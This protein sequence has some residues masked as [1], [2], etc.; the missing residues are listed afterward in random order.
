MYSGLTAECGE[1]KTGKNVAS[2]KVTN[3]TNSKVP[4]ITFPTGIDATVIETKV[5]TVGKGPKITGSQFV[6]F[7]F[8]QASGATGEMTG[9]TKFDGTDIQSQYLQADGELCKA[10]GGV[11]EGSRVA[12]LIPSAIMNSGEEEAS[13]GVIVFDIKKVYLPRAVGDEQ[14]NQSGLPTI[15]RATNGMP[16]IQFTTGAAPTELKVVPLIKGWGEKL[17]PNSGQKLMIHY[18]GWVWSSQSKFESSWDNKQPVEFSYATG[19]LIDGMVQ[20]LKDQT[21]GSQVM[22]VIPPALAYKDQA[23]ETIPANSTLIFVIDIL[24]VAK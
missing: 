16:T 10:F 12:L 15:I 5:I 22:L 1:V 6:S 3:G 4:V 23:S 18:A 24:G 20:G 13:S 8:A 9:N 7:E 14:S 2:V 11:T 21:V 17:V 19:S